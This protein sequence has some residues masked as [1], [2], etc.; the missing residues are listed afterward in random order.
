VAFFSSA[1][2]EI[3]RDGREEGEQIYCS[4]LKYGYFS[5]DYH[6]LNCFLFLKAQGTRR[7]RK[8][9][10]FLASNYSL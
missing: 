9:M 10:P 1:I 2:I 6:D 3:W 5:L 8:G 4:S 7:C